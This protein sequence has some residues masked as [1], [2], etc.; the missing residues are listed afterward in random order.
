MADKIDINSAPV[1]ILT[2]LPGVGIN[3]AYNIVNHRTRHGFFVDWAE[4]GAV[5]E[6]PMEKLEQ[7]RERAEL[8]QPAEGRPT[9]TLPKPRYLKHHTPGE[10]KGT[11]GYT[12]SMRS[13]RRPDRLHD[14]HDHSHHGGDSKKP[15]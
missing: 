15:A 5:K 1:N 13:T 11:E 10:Q 3:V 6:F 8:I 2:Q 14:S 4:L 7:I 9:E 12:K